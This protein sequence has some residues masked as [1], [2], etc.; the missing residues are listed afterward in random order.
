MFSRISLAAGAAAGGLVV[1]L[2]M[3]AVN[4]IWL[5]PAARSEARAAE[6]VE[7]Q[8]AT[9]KAIGELTNAADRAR[10][11]RRLCLERGWVYLNGS[12]QCVERATQ[13]DG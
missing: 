2:A 11:N 7:A 12:G 4:V 1:F 10:V 5:L 9:T 8:A 13:P 3:Q 6:R